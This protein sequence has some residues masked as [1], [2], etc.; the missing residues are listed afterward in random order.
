MTVPPMQFWNVAHDPH[1]NF[2]K[3]WYRSEVRPPGPRKPD[4]ALDSDYALSV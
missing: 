2:G 1:R 3:P 4:Y